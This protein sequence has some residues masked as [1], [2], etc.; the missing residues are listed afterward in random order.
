MNSVR[1]ADALVRE[2]PA[3]ASFAESASTDGGVRRTT[4]DG[5]SAPRTAPPLNLK[6]ARHD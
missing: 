3:N 6:S 4:A 2:R 1:G 5:A